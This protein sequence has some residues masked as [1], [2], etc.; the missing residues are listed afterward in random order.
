MNRETNDNGIS[1]ET[2]SWLERMLASERTQL[3]WLRKR[4]DRIERDGPKIATTIAE[5][6]AVR[7]YG[8]WHA[9]SLARFDIECQAE[10][11]QIWGDEKEAIAILSLQH[12]IEDRIDIHRQEEGRLRRL[13]PKETKHIKMYNTWPA[14]YDCEGAIEG[15]HELIAELENTLAKIKE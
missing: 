12:A 8:A 7:E 14:S 3:A 9:M 4:E 11:L 1:P 6:E 5:C 10:S 13:T 15:K 2:I